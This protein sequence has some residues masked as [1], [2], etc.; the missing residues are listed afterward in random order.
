MGQWVHKTL[1][2]RDNEKNVKEIKREPLIW[3]DTHPT[4][5]KGGKLELATLTLLF[6]PFFSL[7]NKKIL[8]LDKGW[9]GQVQPYTLF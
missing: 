6:F 2:P 9:P 7:Y 1:H 3:W 4:C 5:P 8:T